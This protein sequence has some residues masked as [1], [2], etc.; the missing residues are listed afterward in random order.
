MRIV[1]GSLRGRTIP[2][3]RCLADIRLTSAMLKEAI[4]SMLGSDLTGCAFLDLCAGSGQVGLEAASR[5]AQVLL[6]EPDH[7]RCEQIRALVSQWRVED[8]RVECVRAQRL[9]PLL[10][11]QGSRFDVIYVDPPYHALRDGRPL[12]LDLLEGLGDA[13]LLCERGL[14][15]VQHQ[16][17]LPLPEQVGALGVLRRRPYGT[18]TL[19]VYGC[20]PA[21]DQPVP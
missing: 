11:E 18:T 21:A 5:G 14:V 12:S 8:A 3:R 16:S 2:S 9:I 20:G 7:R 13:H 19:S 4:F 15:L 17:E 6:N 1:S 10:Q